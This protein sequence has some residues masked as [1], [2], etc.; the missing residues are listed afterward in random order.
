MV[1]FYYFMDEF[2]TTDEWLIILSIIVI[3]HCIMQVFLFNA[4]MMVLMEYNSTCTL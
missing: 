4:Y 1:L 3:K 2:H